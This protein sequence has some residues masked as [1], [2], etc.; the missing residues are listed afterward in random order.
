MDPGKEKKFPIDLGGNRGRGQASAF[1]FL[2][3]SEKSAAVSLRDDLLE[4]SDK[5]A[6]TVPNAARASLVQAYKRHERS[7][8]AIEM[9]Y[10]SILAQDM[11]KRQ[12]YGFKPPKMGRRTDAQADAEVRARLY[13]V[14][15]DASALTRGSEL[16][17]WIAAPSRG[18]G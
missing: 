18:P 3:H 14:P 5:S 4:P 1:H 15:Y 9:A 7:R 13:P 17:R 16:R 2:P 12:K 11:K 10:E 6:Q 8:E